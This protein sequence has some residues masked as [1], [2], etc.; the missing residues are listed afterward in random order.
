MIKLSK[1]SAIIA[2]FSISAILYCL[3][4]WLKKMGIIIPNWIFGV[5]GFSG[6]IYVA[7]KETIIPPEYRTA[8]E[9]YTM[10]ILL[11]AITLII[12]PFIF[13]PYRW[14]QKTKLIFVDDFAS[15]KGWQQYD[16]GSVEIKEGISKSHGRALKKDKNADPSGGYLP[17]G[18]TLENGFCFSGWIYSPKER[19]KKAW[20]DRLAI[21]G[22]NFNGYGFAV[23]QFQGW[24]EIERRDGG[25]TAVCISERVVFSPPKESWYRFEFIR[26]KSGEM[27]LYLYDSSDAKLVQVF[28]NDKEYNSFNRIAVHGGYPYYIDDLKITTT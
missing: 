15:D 27:T 26:L 21:E 11:L 5:I 1:F 13:Q 19:G 3:K 22:D 23:A 18:K 10:Y 4:G 20:G 2:T 28:A 7:I 14:F 12:L 25:N 16:N 6:L 24:A 17:I 9:P 8:I